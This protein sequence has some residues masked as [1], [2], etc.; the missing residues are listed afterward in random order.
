[1]E[2][3]KSHRYLK[4]DELFHNLRGSSFCWQS[5]AAINQSFFLILQSFSEKNLKAAASRQRIRKLA[6]QIST[7]H[8]LKAAFEVLVLIFLS[9]VAKG[10]KAT[11]LKN[12]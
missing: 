9:W 3:R 12:N 10:I 11:N 6:T 1:L 2:E 8:Q 5:E 4:V 7:M